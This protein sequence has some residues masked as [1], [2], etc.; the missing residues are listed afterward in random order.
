[1]SNTREILNRKIEDYQRFINSGAFTSAKNEQFRKEIET[2]QEQLR[3]QETFNSK[4]LN[5]TAAPVID[6]TKPWTDE[7]KRSEGMKLQ[8]AAFEM[9]L[10]G[11][12]ADAVPV[13][14]RTYTPLGT[15]SG[16][17]GQYLVPTSVSLDIDR[18]VKSSGQIISAVAPVPT[19]N[20][21]AFNF[22]TSDDTTNGGE[23]LAENGPIGQSNPVF[24]NV[25]LDSFQ[26]SSQEILAAISLVQDAAYPLL[27]NLT[28]VFAQ[29]AA[30]GW[31]TRIITDPTD[32]LLNVTGSGSLTAASPTV[33]SF[34]EA[35]TLQSK[36]D[37]GYAMRGTYFMNYSTFI[38]Y[39]GLTATT[40]E[41]L[42]PAS[43]R[44]AGLLWG[45]PFVIAQDMPNAAH[46]A[47]YLGFGDLSKVKF[48]KVSAMTVHV[49]R[50]AFMSNLQIG[51]LAQQRVSSK[52]IQPKAIAFL[53]GA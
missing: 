15:T 27:D 33:L 8:R 7:H 22:P 48:R 23:F 24:G 11:F 4:Y 50:E 14:L 9:T 28:E 49:L 10:R 46:S 17:V 43:E 39:A 44:N 6:V 45:R 16:P 19:T 1:M 26:W 32:G 52:C 3:A 37:A 21:A 2:L 18:L 20:G 36:V 51:F 31:S 42:W 47:K 13:Q 29:R 30:R 5:M 12:H 40:G 34:L 41:F 35:L 53:Q 38:G 25:E